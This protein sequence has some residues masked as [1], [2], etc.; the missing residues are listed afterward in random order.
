MMIYDLIIIGGGPAGITAGIYG[1]RKALKILLLTKDFVGQIGKVGLI[2][3]Y[4]GFVEVNGMSL[5][6]S[7]KDHLQKFD[8]E[9]KE[10]DEVRSLSK[11]ENIFT[12]ETVKKQLFQSKA[13]IIAT[14]RNPRPLKVPGEIELRNKG[15]SYCSICDAPLFRGRDVAVIGGGNSG[16]GAALDSIPYAN[17][18]YI[19]EISSKP[20]ADE[21]EQ[22]KAN[23][24]E[25]IE[26]ILRAKTL[27]IKGKDKIE[28]LV[29]QDLESGQKKE[30]A[31]QGVFI[32]VGYL[33]AADFL[34]DLVD[35]TEMGEVIVDP[36]TGATKT[37][38]LYAAGDVTDVKYKQIVVAAGEG[39]KALL[40]AYSFLQ[41]QS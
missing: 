41:N 40:S 24:S 32:Q 30:L 16:F 5:M 29:Y 6:K 12:I 21:I 19:L 11:K 20:L 36:L 33:P 14:G 31:V 27:E 26:V 23:R 4:P 8:L 34:K 22:E 7:F 10:G 25:K 35:L 15:V 13:V 38:G 9:I 17:K 28:M 1:A 3:N 2:E 37:L 39:T 18:I